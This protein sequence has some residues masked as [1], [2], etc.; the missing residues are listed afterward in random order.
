MGEWNTPSGVFPCLLRITTREAGFS[1]VAARAVET[2]GTGMPASTIVE[3]WVYDAN[4]D[5]YP[6]ADGNKTFASCPSTTCITYVYN[7]STK[8]FV[9]SSGA[10]AAT[11]INACP[12][13]IDMTSI[14][15]YIKAHH[16]FFTSLFGTGV[17]IGDHAVMR[18]EPLSADQLSNGETCM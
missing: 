13:N 17:D 10:W 11:S 16:G 8:A 7:A 6:G 2:A 1:D 4:V 18:F 9:V 3:M 5:G 12:G 14:G 15:I